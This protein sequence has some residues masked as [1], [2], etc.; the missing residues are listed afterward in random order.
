MM[1]LPVPGPPWTRTTEFF[2]LMVAIASRSQDRFERDALLVKERELAVRLDHRR[3]VLEEL[4]AR[5]VL[6]LE[7]ARHHRVSVAG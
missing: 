6:R 2:G 5:P 4:A 3:D 1:D 7:H